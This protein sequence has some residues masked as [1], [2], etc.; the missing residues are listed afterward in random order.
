MLQ[1]YNNSVGGGRGE[2][3]VIMYHFI[4]IYTLRWMRMQKTNGMQHI[5]RFIRKRH[6]G[7]HHDYKCHYDPLLKLS[8]IGSFSLFL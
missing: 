8:M 6:L 5:G 1:A 3:G 7:V 4:M 2:G